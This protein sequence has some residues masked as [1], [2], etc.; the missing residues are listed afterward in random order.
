MVGER[1]ILNNKNVL[2]PFYCIHV[3]H[4]VHI[5]Q[6]KFVHPIWNTLE[7]NILSRKTTFNY[8]YT[9][10]GTFIYQNYFPGHNKYHIFC[11]NKVFLNSI[12]VNDSMLNNK[13]LLLFSINDEI[14]QPMICDNL[15]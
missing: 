12:K 10:D 13:S 9:H 1:V 7:K 15:I 2:I 14:I 4:S 3:N 8:T 6:G 5:L 11:N